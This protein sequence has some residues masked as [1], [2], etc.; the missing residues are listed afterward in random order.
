MVAQS[1]KREIAGD[2]S[3]TR[4][5]LPRRVDQMRIL[6]WFQCHLTL[7][8]LV[9][10]VIVGAIVSGRELSSTGADDPVERQLGHIEVLILAL[11]ATAILLAITAALVR[12]GFAVAFPLVILCELAVLV[13]VGLALRAGVVLSIVTLLLVILGAWIVSNLVRREVWAFLLRSSR[14]SAN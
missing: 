5:E 4:P 7:V 13:D 2:S 14:T 9:V 8:T 11:P 3:R 12:R 1:S 10:S 6:T